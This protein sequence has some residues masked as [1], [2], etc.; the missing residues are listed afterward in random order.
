MESNKQDYDEKMMQFTETLKFLRAFMMDHNN[1][2]K[3]SP[4]QKDSYNP[5]DPITMVPSNRRAPPLEGVHYTE[6]FDMWIL[7]HEIKSPNLY[8]LLIKTELKGD[9]TLDLKNFYKHISM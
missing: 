3:S 9:T 7:K 2:S 6:I 4:T 5:P 8:E 1:I